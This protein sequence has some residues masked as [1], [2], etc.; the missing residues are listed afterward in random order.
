MSADLAMLETKVPDLVVPC[1][2][3][4]SCK[5]VVAANLRT[6][7]GRSHFKSRCRQGIQ[8]MYEMYWLTVHLLYMRE[9]DGKLKKTIRKI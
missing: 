4:K 5:E 7:V 8:L 2:W 9:S 1:R 3:P 6:W